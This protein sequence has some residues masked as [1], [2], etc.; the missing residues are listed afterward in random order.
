MQRQKGRQADLPGAS[1]KPALLHLS[2]EPRPHGWG[3]CLEKSHLECEEQTGPTLTGV[4]EP[5]AATFWGKH[6]T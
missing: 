2:L 6:H 1:F 4:R 5:T 3:T